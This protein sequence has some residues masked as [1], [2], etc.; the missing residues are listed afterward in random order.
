MALTM[1][2]RPTGMT[3]SI[4]DWN[5][6]VRSTTMYWPQAFTSIQLAAGLAATEAAIQGITDGLIVGGSVVFELISDVPQNAPADITSDVERKGSFVFDLENGE[7]AKYEIP[8]LDKNLVYQG[9]NEINPNAAAVLAYV[10]LMLNGFP[11]AD[12]GPVSGGG[13]PIIGLRSAKQIHR[14]SSKG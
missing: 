10:G 12:N 2:D 13:S 4:K 11:G 8:S 5:K 7:T 9:T 6:N 14:K 3:F 1:G